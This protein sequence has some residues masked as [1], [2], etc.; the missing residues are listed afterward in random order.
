MDIERIA[1]RLICIG[2]EMLYYRAEQNKIAMRPLADYDLPTRDRYE[3]YDGIY[4]QLILEDIANH[5]RN[6]VRYM[7]TN[8]VHCQDLCIKRVG[9]PVDKVY[10]E[11]HKWLETVTHRN[12][13]QKDKYR[14]ATKRSAESLERYIADQDSENAKKRERAKTRDEK[15]SSLFDSYVRYFRGLSRVSANTIEIQYAL[16]VKLLRTEAARRAW[17]RA[18]GYKLAQIGFHEICSEPNWRSRLDPNK[19]YYPGDVT[20]TPTG[21]VFIEFNAKEVKQDA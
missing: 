8:L 6:E 15:I 12:Q 20:T 13:E 11:F 1:R 16:N 17:V 9:K 5:K 3:L 21:D 14:E 7:G 10:V 19:R 18:N 4:D 2:N